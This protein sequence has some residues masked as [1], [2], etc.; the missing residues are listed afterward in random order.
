MSEVFCDQS[1]QI[2]PMMVQYLDVKKRYPECLVFFRLGDFFEL[3]FNDATIA[4]QILDIA[5]TTRGKHLDQEIPMCGVPAGSVNYYLS[6]LIKA[7]YKVAICD[8]LENPED[9]KKLR[10]YKAVVK[11]DVVRVVTPGTIVDENL[12][13][14]KSN[15]FLMSIV[16]ES[17]ANNQQKVSFAAIDISTDQFFTNTIAIEDLQ[18]I[19]EILLPIS[20]EN[21]DFLLS[22]KKMI[23]TNI[24]TLPESKF[25]PI[26]E[27]QRLE[28]FF[29][30]TTLE[31][32]GITINDECA[33]CGAV[34][35]YLI[36][37]QKDNIKKLGYPKKINTSQFLIIDPATRNNLE[38]ASSSSPHQLTLFTVLDKTKTAF[39]ARLLASRITSPLKKKELIE[40]RLNLVEFYVINNELREKFTEI[41]NKC[42]DFQR[43]LMRFK[44]AKGSPADLG[45]IKN[46]LE[47]VV[48]IC[49]LA[50]DKIIPE[51]ENFS[52]S[53]IENFQ[54]FVNLL[55]T[56][57][58]DKLP[59][60][61][62]DG[63]IIAPG[64]DTYLDDLRNIRDNI[65]DLLYQLQT[66]YISQSGINT[67]KIKFNNIVGWYIEIPK[68]QKNKMGTEFI[69]RQTL[70]NSVRYT[71]IELQDLQVKFFQASETFLD[72]EIKIFQNIVDML[73][74]RSEKISYAIQV[75]AITDVATN[76]ASIAVAKNYVRPILDYSNSL[77]IQGG[78]HPVI[79][80]VVSE[81]IENDCLLSRE[82]ISILLTGPNMAGKSTYLRQNALII[83]MAQIG[84]FVSAKSATIGIVDKIF[85]RIGA[86]DDL[87]RG[88]STFMVEMIETATILN[89]ATEK[90]FVILDEVGRGTSTYDGLSIAWSVME[91]LYAINKCRV[92]FATHYRE[93][94]ALQTELPNLICQTLKVQEWKGDVVFFHKIIDGIAD[95][96]YG[97]HVANLAGLPK[98][99]ISRAKE[100][101]SK[102]ESENANPTQTNKKHNHQNDK[103]LDIFEQNIYS[104]NEKY[105]QI[106]SILSNLD[107]DSITPINA[108]TLLYEL[109]NIVTSD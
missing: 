78:R 94:T 105:K 20:L 75:L 83:L 8:Q 98:K 6:R 58:V 102:F 52:I 27:R 35:E 89:Q 41:L 21:S 45:I 18:Q 23:H 103:Q 86:S 61:H 63:G 49:A 68:S 80:T 28:Q 19:I 1:N 109:K 36:I 46:G 59:V 82:N 2:T 24:T 104:T 70:V 15:N 39:G 29:A 99:V 47:C 4:S 76:F 40:Q 73:I 17:A 66:K 56:A 92:I 34:L 37:T 108:L 93:L 107:T 30:V 67:L 5:L 10:G 100:L 74:E 62:K 91:H 55:N 32:F 96:S 85:S 81:F 16:P 3:F 12:L 88:R 14:A 53:K 31:S 95:K 38:I 13:E 69:H 22:L 72:Y 79:E 60:S 87:A 25:N 57:L 97:I 51:E 106:E 7:G 84:S 101:L 9:A 54:N 90:S 43:A 65:Q 26:L 64:Y 42:P 48:N 33:A 77:I 71:T 50:L 44:F 11:R